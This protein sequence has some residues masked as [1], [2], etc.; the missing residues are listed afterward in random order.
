MNSVNFVGRI[1]KEP[2]YKV[3]ISGKSLCKFIIAVKSNFPTKTNNEENV[4]FVSCI[5]WGYNAE[6][7]YK[8]AGKGRLI[9]LTGELRNRSWN[10]QDGTKAY[11]TEIIVGNLDILDYKK[12]VNDSQKVETVVKKEPKV[13]D[14]YPDIDIA[15]FD[16]FKEDIE[17]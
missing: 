4:S 7:V 1:A 2:D 9:S 15:T 11:V 5:C 8:Y 6:I 14:K 12:E 17:L 13:I 10:N 3:T 16:P